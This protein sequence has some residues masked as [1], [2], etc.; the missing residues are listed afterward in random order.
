MKL[1]LILKVTSDFIDT[2]ISKLVIVEE[3]HDPSGQIFSHFQ[4]RTSKATISRKKL[5][6]KHF[7]YSLQLHAFLV[8]IF[9]NL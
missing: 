6:F 1:L 8:S 3:V 9:H 4:S 5:N 7:L 2:K